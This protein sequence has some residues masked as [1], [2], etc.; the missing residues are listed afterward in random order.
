[1]SSQAFTIGDQVFFD[2]HPG[3]QSTTRQR[4]IERV[5]YGKGASKWFLRS[6][7]GTGKSVLIR[8]G[9]CHALALAIPGF[10]YVVV[11]RNYPDLESNHLIYVG[12][13]MRLLGGSFN[14]T[15]RI[16][17]YPV[18]PKTGLQSMGFY[19][20]C[21]EFR[22]VEKIV[23]AEG[24]VLFVD[25]SPQ[26]NWDYLMLMLPSLRVPKS[27]DGSQPY[28]TCAIFSGNPTGESIEEHDDH[29][30]DQE[31]MK[32]E[33]HPYYDPK[34]WQHVR[35][36]AED[37]PSIDKDEYLKMLGPIP[38]AFR[39]AWID[40]VRMESRTLFQIHKTK[41]GRPYHY[42]SE[43][44]KVGND[45]LLRVPWVQIHRAYDHG[46]FPDPA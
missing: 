33:D 18:D 37:N 3:V 16:A 24:A 40:G 5:L 31:N 17:M 27:A 6:R 10:K 41:H 19:R 42:I 13:E 9:V 21:E 8:K 46:F 36:V 7:R 44:P 15:K 11:R 38:P 4:L 32:V 23:G 45:P 22:D 34:D 12:P 25:E 1:M 39:A 20:Q 26:I 35:L 29:F 14:E 43:L 30:V 2:P 28:Y